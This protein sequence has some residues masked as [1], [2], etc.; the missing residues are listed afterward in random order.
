MN[1]CSMRFIQSQN[2]QVYSSLVFLPRDNCA[3]STI[4]NYHVEGTL[5]SWASSL[6]HAN[7]QCLASACVMKEF[8]FNDLI[9][10]TFERLELSLDEVDD[11][12]DYELGG[13]VLTVQF[14]NGTT[15]VFSRQPPTRQLWMAAIAGGFHFEFDEQAQDWRN[16]RDATLFTPFVIEQMQAQGGIE[17]SWLV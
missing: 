8:E 10:T 13:G 3:F 11:D 12:I 1:S 2:A 17:F 5:L 6:Y 14:V 4:R 15:M 16:T 7:S 9:D